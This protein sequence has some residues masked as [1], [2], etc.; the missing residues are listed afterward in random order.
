MDERAVGEIRCDLEQSLGGHFPAELPRA[1]TPHFALGDTRLWLGEMSNACW[2]R[3]AMGESL[4]VRAP[5]QDH[6][7]VAFAQTIPFR[8]KIRKGERKWI[9]KEAFSDL[10]PR[11]IR[12]RPKWGFYST[13]ITL[14]ENFTEIASGKSVKPGGCQSCKLS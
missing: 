1:F 13:G 10:L 4:E 7:L 6:N 8:L 14:G 2:D 9:L 5:L 3:V 11:A 12:N